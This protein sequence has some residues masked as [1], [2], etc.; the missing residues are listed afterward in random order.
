MSNTFFGKHSLVFSILSER[1]YYETDSNLRYSI[2]CRLSQV[3]N[4]YDVTKGAV[5][6]AFFVTKTRA[7]RKNREI[8]LRNKFIK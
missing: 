7:K 6:I 3:C 2:H 1:I 8:Q 5:E 4:Y